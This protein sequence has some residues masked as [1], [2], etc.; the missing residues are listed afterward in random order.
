[1]SS[2]I[3]STYRNIYHNNSNALT[4]LVCCPIR[5]LHQS[6]LLFCFACPLPSHFFQSITC[7]TVAISCVSGLSEMYCALSA[8][9][10]ESINQSYYGRIRPPRGAS[11]RLLFYRYFRSDMVHHLPIVVSCITFVHHAVSRRDQRHCTT[12]HSKREIRKTQM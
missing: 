7:V 3:E 12:H 6:S 10:S 2:T 1:M 11:F 9:L 8:Q 5:C 4:Q